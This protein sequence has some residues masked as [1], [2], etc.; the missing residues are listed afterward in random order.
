MTDA[1]SPMV[2]L[3]SQLRSNRLKLPTANARSRSEG[4]SRDYQ[5]RLNQEPVREQQLADLT[6]GYEQSK[7]NY[8]DLL[9]EEE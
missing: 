3:Q 7:A 4:E 2:Q 5:A 9:K 8:D 1:S 6:R